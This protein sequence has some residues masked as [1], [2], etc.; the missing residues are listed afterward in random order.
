MLT[1]ACPIL[2]STN[3]K[4]TKKFYNNLGFEFGSEYPEQ[5]YLILHRN[6][7]ELHFFKS[8]QHVAETSDHGVFIRTEDVDSLSKEYSALNLPADGIP[9]FTQAE[10]KP[11]GVCELAV[12]D[13]DGNLLRIGQIMDT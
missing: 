3:F 2:P 6:N 13:T 7:I 12:V 4:A 9:R 11:W 5:G 8:P 1:H 10:N